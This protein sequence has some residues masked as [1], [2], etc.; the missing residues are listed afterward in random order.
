MWKIRLQDLLFG[1]S[2][3]R[4]KKENASKIA[5][6]LFKSC[7]TYKILETCDDTV[8]IRC[9]HSKRRVVKAI[10][11]VTDYELDNGGLPVYLYRKLN[12]VGIMIGAVMCVF[13]IFLS[14]MIVWDIEVSG[15]EN[16][17]DEFIKNALCDYGLVKGKFIPSIDLDALHNRVLL[18]NGSI[19]WLRV[20]FRGTLALVEVIEYEGLDN[21]ITPQ[22]GS[23]LVASRDALIVS[24]FTIQGTPAVKV[25]DTVKEGDLLIGG[26]CDSNLR[27]YSVKNA[28]G[29]VIGEVWDEVSVKIPY[30]INEK[31]YTG[32]TFTEKSIEILGKSIKLSKNSRNYGEKCDIIEVVRRLEPYDFIKLPIEYR[33]ITYNRYEITKRSITQDEALALANEELDKRLRDMSQ[34]GDIVSIKS[35]ISYD[36]ECLTL[37]ST[38]FR[39]EDIGKRVA[40]STSIS[41]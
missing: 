25:G 36:A 17:S 20:N 27:G 12:R 33:E 23:N 24:M 14:S 1:Y 35:E 4:V 26:I 9:S 22:R 41:N 40:L 3:I 15:N 5:D 7:I 37:H 11:D 38:I 21:D 30:E 10:A 39:T 28:E 18:D 19:G 29:D 32:E 34:R 8:L 16:L 13:M 2:M 31:S 6:A